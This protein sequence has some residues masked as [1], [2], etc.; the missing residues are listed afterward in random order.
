MIILI[1]GGTGLIGTQLTGMAR[2][3]GHEVRILTRRPSAQGH[4]QWDPAAG[5]IDDAALDGVQVVINLAGAGIADKRWTEAR[6]RELIESRIQS[7]DTLR[8]A[9]ER[10]KKRPDVYVAASAIGIYGDSGET[11]VDETYQTDSQDF[12]VVCCRRWEEAT[13]QVTALGIRTVTLRIG[14]VL[15]AA[16][17]ALQEFVRPLRLGVGGYFGDGQAWFSWI[18]YYDMCKMLLWAAQTPHL[19][20]VYNA[21]APHP[22]RNKPVVQAIGR[23][24]GRWAL[25]LPAPAWVMRLALGE[26]SAVVLNSNRVSAQRVLDAGFEFEYP[27]LDDALKN[28]L[29]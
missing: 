11:L 24:M 8:A 12:M 9:L 23:A 18:H 6:K 26:M 14:V 1:A 16:G 17:G 7:A 5:T 10:T 4:F 19:S 3:A 15:A 13:Q 21:V 28:I 25:Y 29:G 27:D 22:V 2:A 20:G